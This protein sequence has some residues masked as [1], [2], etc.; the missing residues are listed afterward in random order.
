MNTHVAE[1][2]VYKQGSPLWYTQVSPL[3]GGV[4]MNVFIGGK[5]VPHGIRNHFVY[6]LKHEFCDTILVDFLK[7]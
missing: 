6:E 4:G 1:G 5:H 7:W 3:P 2:G